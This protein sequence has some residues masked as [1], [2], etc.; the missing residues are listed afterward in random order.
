MS[1]KFAAQL[2]TLRNELKKNFP[3]VLRELKKMGW[4]GVQID[5]L[6]GYEAE[7]IAEVLKETG[8]ETAGMHISLDRMVNDVDEILKES[9]LFESKDIF[10]HYL[11]TNMQTEQ[12]YIEAKSTLLNVAKKLNPLGFRVGYHNHDF[13]F[14]TK[15]DGEYALDY[16]LA[17]A[18]NTFVYPEI[19]TY[20]VK[21][22]GK[23]PL[24]FMKKYVGRTPILH[25][26]DMTADGKEFFAEVGTGLIDFKPILL[27]GEKTGVEWY[28]VEQDE[29]SGS[30]FDSLEISLRNLKEMEKQIK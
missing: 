8:L 27:W 18:G 17:P 12:G 30:P 24:A 26:K 4:T 6:F 15:V 13:E 16:L 9:R 11:D 2:Y 20:W 10:C 7:E 19:D 25:L 29:C 22:F 14:H 5:G 1:L 23:D 28:A 3:D 21:K